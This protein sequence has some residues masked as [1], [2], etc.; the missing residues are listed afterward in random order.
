[1][2]EAQKTAVLDLI[3]RVIDEAAFCSAYGTA[4]ND[5]PGE[6][7]RILEEARAKHDGEAVEMALLL[8]ARFGTPQTAI[9][10]LHTLLVETWHTSHEAMVGLLQEWRDPAS[11]PP[12]KQA[13]Q[14][15][16]RLAHFDY[17]DYGAFY[18]K[19]LWAL[20]EIGT[21]DAVAVIKEC[22]ASED[23]VLR[24]QT[25]YRLGKLGTFAQ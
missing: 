3:T 20:T 12:L 7:E 21:T 19:C 4:P 8:G 18:K 2:N 23:P 16:P 6:I 5:L 17:D 24:E 22:A 1:M 9:S 11:V 13:I 14:L 15:K 10:T 25:A